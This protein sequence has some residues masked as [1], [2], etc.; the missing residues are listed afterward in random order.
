M[1]RTSN[2]WWLPDEDRYFA[3][4]LERDNGFQLERLAE[5]LRYVTDWSIAVDGGAHVGTWSHN[6]AEHFEAVY[7]YEPQPETY[8]CLTRNMFCHR[9]VRCYRAAISDRSGLVD[10]HLDAK[11]AR[12]GNTGSYYAQFAAENSGAIA[13]PCYPLDDLGLSSLGL[14]KLDVEGAEILALR[15]AVETLRRCRPVVIME[16]KAGYA[17]R[18]GA[19]DGDAARF[20]EKLGAREVARIKADRIYRF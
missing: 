4:F 6:L 8:K 20:I 1:K 15:G 7:A 19:Q 11:H 17:A 2:G 18:F 10:M 3:P 16:E 9:N 14:L 5:A 13:T 12:K